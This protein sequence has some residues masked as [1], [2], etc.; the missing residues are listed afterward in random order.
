MNLQEQNSISNWPEMINILLKEPITDIE[1]N[2]T[3][4]EA[5]RFFFALENQL[6]TYLTALETSLTKSLK[7]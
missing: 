7:R 3:M 2:M 6:T 1:E 4:A 5:N